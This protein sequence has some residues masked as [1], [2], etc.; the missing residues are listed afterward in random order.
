MYLQITEKEY[1]TIVALDHVLLKADNLESMQKKL[2][3]TWHVWFQ[4]NL[5]KARKLEA[6]VNSLIYK[7]YLCT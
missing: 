3:F 2:K 4:H 5:C 6:K 7:C 1:T